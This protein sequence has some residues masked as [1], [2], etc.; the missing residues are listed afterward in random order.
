MAYVVSANYVQNDLPSSL[1]FEVK[2]MVCKE[3]S[4]LLKSMSAT[5]YLSVL[6]WYNM[7]L[8]K[9]WVSLFLSWSGISKCN[10]DYLQIRLFSN[11]FE[12]RAPTAWRHTIENKKRRQMTDWKIVSTTV[13]QCQRQTPET[14]GCYEL[15]AEHRQCCSY[16]Q[17]IYLQ[18]KRP[19]RS[20]IT[21]VAWTTNRG[22]WPFSSL[23][24]F[25][26]PITFQ[27]SSLSCKVVPYFV[28]NKK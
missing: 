14:T 9:I 7:F 24:L 17:W 1:P 21:N 11:W 8:S 22:A 12:G 3:L 27:W 13:Q 5:L 20:W 15:S 4:L 2:A 18:K 23:C 28:W 19:I 25:Y 26:Y 6:V 16:H 10:E